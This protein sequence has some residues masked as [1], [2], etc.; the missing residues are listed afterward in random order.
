M[1]LKC[2]IC[3][4][5]QVAAINL[6]I[7]KGQLSLRG[8]ARQYGVGDDSLL[9]HA[10]NCLAQTIRQSKEL[11][12]MLQASNLCEQLSIWHDRMDEQYAKADAAGNFNAVIGIARTAVSTIDA[13]AKIR[14]TSELEQ[15]VN[16]LEQRDG[17]GHTN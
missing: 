14:V 2:S 13:Y 1:S 9:R 5:A 16:D 6:D 12:T 7:L 8:V 17:H 10:H 4:N 3:S 15:R 11:S